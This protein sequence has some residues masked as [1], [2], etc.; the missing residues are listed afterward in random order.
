MTRAESGSLEPIPTRDSLRR[1]AINARTRRVLP[2]LS[3]D[4][5]L[6]TLPILLPFS[7]ASFASCFFRSLSFPSFPPLL[8]LFNRLFCCFALSRMHLRPS[9]VSFRDFLELSQITPFQLQLSIVTALA[10]RHFLAHGRFRARD[11]A[12]LR[13]PVEGMRSCRRGSGL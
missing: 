9:A 2:M 3:D 5:F 6:L 7:S 12:R 1:R 10:L 11:Q 13:A 4:A 8:S